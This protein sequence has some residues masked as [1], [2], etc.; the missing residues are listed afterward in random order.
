MHLQNSTMK[1]RTATYSSSRFALRSSAALQACTIEDTGNQAL[2][3][4]LRTGF[5][6]DGLCIC[7]GHQQISLR[8]T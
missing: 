1:A 4:S 8:T 5:D 6:K 2:G 7:Q 3:A